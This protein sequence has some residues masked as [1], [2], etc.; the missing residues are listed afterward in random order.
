[1]EGS[2]GSNGSGQGDLVCL[3]C[4]VLGINILARFSLIWLSNA[5]LKIISFLFYFYLKIN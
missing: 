3:N 5:N 4:E 1:M 2:L